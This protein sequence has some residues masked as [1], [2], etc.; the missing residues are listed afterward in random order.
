FFAAAE[1][2]LVSLSESQVAQLA[3]QGGRGRAVQPL[4][5]H[6]N[7]FLS[8]VQI[9]V[10]LAGFLSAAFGASTIADDVTPV[11]A[12]WGLSPGVAQEVYLAPITLVIVYLSLV[13]GELAPKRLALQRAEGLA[14]FAAPVIE[15][16]AK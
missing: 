14:L 6:P 11:L 7:R 2:A 5:Q 3:Q 13:L 16:I 1:I 15:S 8:A 10:T 4:Q 12:D 9:G